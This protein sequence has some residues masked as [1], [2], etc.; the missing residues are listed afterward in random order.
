MG[1][2][3]MI[4]TGRPSVMGN[5]ALLAHGQ[6]SSLSFGGGD[7]E[8]S[9]TT[10][11]FD[12]ILGRKNFGL[13]FGFFNYS[14]SFGFLAAD[15]ESHGELSHN[16]NIA[17]LSAG[18]SFSKNF[19][20]GV[21]FQNISESF[22][23]ESQKYEDSAGLFNLGFLWKYKLLRAGFY[24][25]NV[26][27]QKIWEEDEL[28]SYSKFAIGYETEKIKVGF[29]GGGDQVSGSANL[30][31][32]YRLFR[33]FA[34]RTGVESSDEAKTT[35]FGFSLNFG[36]FG[37]DFAALSHEDLGSTSMTALKYAWGGEK[38]EKVKKEPVKKVPPPVKPELVKEMA[39]VELPELPESEKINIAVTDFEARAPLSQSEAAFISD[40]VRADIVGAGRFNVVDKNNMDKVL[41]E[42]GFQQTGCSSAE[43]AVRIGKILN[44]KMMIVGSCGQLLGK[45]IITLNVVSVES[46]K[47]IYSDD[48]SVADPDDLRDNIR[49]LIKKFS[50]TIK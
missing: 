36:S 49:A 50:R 7:D 48:I 33:W 24:G 28:P 22:E 39:P 35:T 6:G 42:Q 46:A 44:V 9:A 19:S 23:Y 32:E 43:C 11:K 45:Y 30:G 2:L 1:N 17:S 41:A 14:Q 25:V 8:M 20:M 38:E 16:G 13:G 40:F 15:G 34:L 3:D 47:I 18:Y 37:F 4:F 26:G 5:P 29:A 31:L 12:F 21:G 10:G 27:G